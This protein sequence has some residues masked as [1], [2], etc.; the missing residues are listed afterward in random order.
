M[1]L[2][3]RRRW[4]ICCH[5]KWYSHANNAPFLS[6]IDFK[7]LSLSLIFR[8]LI[9]MYSSTYLFGFILSWVAWLL[10]SVG[11]VLPLSL[12]LCWDPMIQTNVIYYCRPGF[13]YC[14]FFWGDKII[15]FLSLIQIGQIWTSPQVHRSVVS[16]FYY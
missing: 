1:L 9:M 6:P 15:C 13:W 10:K 4:K 2:S 5:L 12:P 7:I 3:S 16:H 11:F 14:Y 8:S